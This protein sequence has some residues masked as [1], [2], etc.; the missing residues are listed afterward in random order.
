MS[1]WIV[2]PVHRVVAYCCFCLGFV[3]QTYFSFI[4]NTFVFLQSKPS[5]LCRRPSSHSWV[6][7]HTNECWLYV[8]PLRVHVPSSRWLCITWLLLLYLLS[9]IGQFD[10][11]RSDNE[12]VPQIGFDILWIGLISLNSL[13]TYWPLLTWIFCKLMVLIHDNLFTLTVVYVIAIC[14]AAVPWSVLDTCRRWLLG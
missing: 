10:C 2:W 12:L 11:N 9:E 6:L 4:L 8:L 5:V 13:Y 14:L 3:D 1:P 7:L